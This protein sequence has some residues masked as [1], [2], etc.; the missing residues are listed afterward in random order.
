MPGGVESS[1]RI[2]MASRDLELMLAAFMFKGISGTSWNNSLALLT[3]TQLVGDF[4]T[5][6]LVVDLE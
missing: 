4:A 6:G 3:I 2:F 1:H 5:G